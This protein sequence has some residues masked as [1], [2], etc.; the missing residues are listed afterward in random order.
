M[1]L[2]QF[3]EPRLARPGG[4]RLIPLR[5]RFP[6][7]AHPGPSTDKRRIL[8]RQRL[9]VPPRLAPNRGE[10]LTVSLHQGLSVPPRRARNRGEGLTVSLPQGVRH[11]LTVP[12]KQHHEQL[13]HTLQ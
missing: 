11:A 4:K 5:Q 8:L 7:P 9:T 12:A 10:V 6:V 3:L 2:R 13:I 1:V